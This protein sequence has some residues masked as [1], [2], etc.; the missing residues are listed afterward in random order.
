M[1]DRTDRNLKIFR[2]LDASMLV[3]IGEKEAS[4]QDGMMLNQFYM[5]LRGAKME[6]VAETIA[7]ERQFLR[8]IADLAY[9]SSEMEDWLAETA[10]A[11]SLPVDMGLGSAV[12][13][14]SAVGAVPISSCNGGAFTSGHASDVAHVLFSCGPALVPDILAAAEA[15]GCGLINNGLHAELYAAKVEDLIAFAEALLRLRAGHRTA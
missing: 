5:D 2:T 3:P 7:F 13:V 10:L 14:L 4:I 9:D 8:E 11:M 6:D 1:E 12:E 15:T